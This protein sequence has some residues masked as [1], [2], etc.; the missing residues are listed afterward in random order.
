[1]PVPPVSAQDRYD[2]PAVFARLSERDVQGIQAAYYT[3]LSFVDYQVGRLLRGLDES[4][5]AGETI[6]AY[7]GDNGYMLG[8][9]GR[10]EKPCFYEPAVRVPLILRWP[11]H[12]P[13]NRRVGDLVE[14]VDVMP[15]VL[16]LIQIAA[17]RGLHGIDL[18]PLLQGTPGA[19]GH[20]VVFS[21]Y[22][23]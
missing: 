2:Q 18:V 16:H 9:H 6:V 19:K 4:G 21:E 20:E 13:A 3:S 11:G 22:L 15:T 7:T 12:L 1:F 17:P 5:L 23:E 8:Q 14:L 10:F